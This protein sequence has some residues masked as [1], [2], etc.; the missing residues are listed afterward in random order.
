MY[1]LQSDTDTYL[2]ILMMRIPHEYMIMSMY[3]NNARS[4]DIRLEESKGGRMKSP[5]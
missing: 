5:A 2:Y 4:R 1:A 3:G